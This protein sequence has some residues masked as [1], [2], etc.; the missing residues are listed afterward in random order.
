M[1]TLRTNRKLNPKEVITKKLK[2]GE[3]VSAESN[4]GVVV[5]KWR[6]KRDVLVLST[7]HNDELV[8][9]RQRRGGE[10]QKPKIISDYNKCK[11]FIDL[12]DQMKAYSSS[13]RKG[14]KWYRKLAIELLLGT[15][16]INAYILHQEVANDNMSI[17]K[18]KESLV[19]QL[20]RVPDDIA[21]H[22]STPR[23]LPV[24]HCLEESQGADRKRGRCV[25]CYK[26]KVE[27]VGSKAAA[28]QTTQS[29]FKCV[30]CKKFY[31][32]P[33]FFKTHKCFID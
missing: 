1:G 26:N 33:C 7:K 9:V 21:D 6:D 32:L 25:Q 4:T 5:L 8:S 2:K 31:C 16:L 10:I 17:T 23:A 15:A 27:E 29:K 3:T 14:I 19:T 30:T 20:L 18:F 12:S 24:E 13:L 28:T 11:S 22:R